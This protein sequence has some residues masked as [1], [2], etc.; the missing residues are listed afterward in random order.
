VEMLITGALTTVTQIGEATH[1]QHDS[2]P[3]LANSGEDYSWFAVQTK[4]RHEKRV[5]AQL[6][7][8][9]VEAFLPLLSE[10]HRWSDRKRQ[11]QVPLFTTYVF[12][13]IGGDKRAR[14]NVLQT[15]G[16]FGF[17]G[18][19]GM[20]V[21]IPDQQIE[22]VQ[23]ILREKVVFSPHPFLDIGQKVRIRGGSLDG[24]CGV[25]SA[26]NGDRS[27]IVSV[28]SIQRSLAIRIDGY[29]IEPV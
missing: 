19:R 27:L 4:A 28:E 3:P 16:V 5:A 7:E 6:E 2:T 10:V 17:V 9:G 15:N 20:G 13:R 22:T 11:V 24:I 29:G 1:L 8:R 12:V 18:I 23:A 14:V 21:P 25:L 26:I